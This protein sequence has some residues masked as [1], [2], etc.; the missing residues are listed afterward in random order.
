LNQPLPGP[1]DPS[2]IGYA[3]ALMQS[4]PDGTPFVNG[5]DPNM[6]AAFTSVANKK[7]YGVLLDQAQQWVAKV[8]LS[9][10]LS[11]SQLG[12]PPGFTLPVGTD[13]TL[14]ALQTPPANTPQNPV[15]FLPTTGTLSLSVTSLDFGSQTV[16][17]TSVPTS[18]TLTNVGSLPLVPQIAIQ[19]ANEGDFVRIPSLVN[20]CTDTLGAQGVCTITLQFTPSAQGPRAAALTVDGGGRLLSVALTG[21]GN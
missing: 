2:Q 11:L 21:N 7:T 15:V 19:G 16:G 12:T 17:T 3:Y 9:L 14:R 6:V 5:P 10:F 20:D 1:P 18:I 8:D 13:V 4:T